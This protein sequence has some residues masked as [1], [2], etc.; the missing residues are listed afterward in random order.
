MKIIQFSHIEK[1]G[2]LLLCTL[3][4]AII[5]TI[6][7]TS[8]QPAQEQLLTRKTDFDSSDDAL[9]TKK[10]GF[11]KSKGKPK[12]TDKNMADHTKFSFDPNLISFDSL[13]RLGLPRK[14]AN[15]WVK[16]LKKGG[17]FRSKEDLLKIYGVEQRWFA[18]IEPLVV[19]QE[20]RTLTPKATE[21]PA[22]HNRSEPITYES[23]RNFDKNPSIRI[24]INAASQEDFMQL[25]GVGQT[26]SNRI[27]KYRESLGGFYAVSQIAEVYGIQDSLFQ[28]LRKQLYLDEVKLEMIAINHLSVKELAKHPYIDFNLAKKI[29][30]F[31]EQHQTIK[32]Q[33]TLKRIYLIDRT[34]IDKLLPYLD[35]GE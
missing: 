3:I 5:I 8:K 18:E 16:Y 1:A 24:D 11:R 17:K 30:S 12:N 7:M 26:L 22:N 21:K 25:K 15:N 31:R 27:I 19:I 23:K 34:A 33:E 28:T 2:I 29:I 32:S 9:P 10:N 20:N 35:F 6:E 4:L 13:I 14:A